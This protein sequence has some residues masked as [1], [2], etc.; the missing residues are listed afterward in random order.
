MCLKR[1]SSQQIQEC[2]CWWSHSEETISHPETI[3][4]CV[5]RRKNASSLCVFFF[6]F[7]AAS[8]R[9]PDLFEDGHAARPASADSHWFWVV[10]HGFDTRIDNMDTWRHLVE[11]IY[12]Y[13]ST[14]KRRYICVNAGLIKCWFQIGFTFYSQSIS[15]WDDVPSRF[16]F[17]WK[18][19]QDKTIAKSNTHWNW[20]PA[21]LEPTSPARSICLVMI[22]FPAWRFYIL[23]TEREISEAR[24]ELR[25]LRWEIFHGSDGYGTSSKWAING[26]WGCVNIRCIIKG[27]LG[28]ETSV[29]RTFRLSGKELVKERVSQRKS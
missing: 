18:Q 24:L 21:S 26:Q 25:W 16:K 13:I 17:C 6:R 15:A 8:S 19:Q 5:G 20:T 3:R 27:S 1:N 29:L 28:G 10:W 9:P 2:D 12:I 22:V 11:Y 14:M 4:C 23:P 7:Q